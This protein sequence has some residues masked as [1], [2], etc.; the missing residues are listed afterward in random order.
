MEEIKINTMIEEEQKL[1]SANMQLENDLDELE[2][3]FSSCKYGHLLWASTVRSLRLDDL[4]GLIL[5][6][7]NGK[8]DYQINWKNQ[9][10]P[11]RILKDY[12]Y[13]IFKSTKSFNSKKQ[14]V[15]FCVK[16]SE[17]K[18]RYKYLF[19]EI[20]KDNFVYCFNSTHV[21]DVTVYEH[22]SLNFS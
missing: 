12:F 10:V 11:L 5:Q 4:E 13:G 16:N 18:H 19:E 21:T 17:K 7:Y 3:F 14:N 9:L 2:S 8:I 1:L 15:W 6:Y 20:K 22:N